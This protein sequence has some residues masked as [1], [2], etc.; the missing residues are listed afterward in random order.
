MERTVW[1]DIRIM[2]LRVD[3]CVELVVHP[4]LNPPPESVFGPQPIPQQDAATTTAIDDVRRD[5][6]Q[7]GEDSQSSSNP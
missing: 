4:E 3:K 2:K 6:A 7:G 1:D 5:G